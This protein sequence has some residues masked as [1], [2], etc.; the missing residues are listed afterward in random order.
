MSV[1]AY[2]LTTSSYAGNKIQAT[3]KVN[4]FSEPSRPIENIRM[5]LQRGLFVFMYCCMQ[6]ML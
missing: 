3:C 1:G 6:L 5:Q 4:K 2:V